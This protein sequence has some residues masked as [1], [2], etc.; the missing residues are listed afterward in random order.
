MFT[1]IEKIETVE[2]MT[3]TLQ[4]MRGTSIYEIEVQNDKT[5]LKLFR[6]V[7]VD[8]AW[9]KKLEKSAVVD[10]KVFV[11]LMNTCKVN[12]WNG[13]H[14]EHPKNVQDG[15]M[16]EFKATVNGTKTISADGSANFP[17]GYSDFVRE[18]GRIL[19]ESETTQ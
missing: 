11:E 9:V 19:A 3:L 7:S 2:S 10:T 15:I 14:G 13:F 4:G 6:E 16:F 1:P 18:L 8:G 17:K 12:S 5:E